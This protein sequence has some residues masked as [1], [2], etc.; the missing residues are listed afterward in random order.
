LFGY[1]FEDGRKY[2]CATIF[3]R[4]KIVP[5]KLAQEKHVTGIV[6]DKSINDFLGKSFNES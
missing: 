1:P 5:S 2:S 3:L 6:I 4:G